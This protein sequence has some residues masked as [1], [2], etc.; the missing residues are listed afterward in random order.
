MKRFLLLAGV[1]VVAAAMYVAASPASQQSKFAT[2]KQV[3]ALQKKVATL[4]K[5]LKSVKAEADA[6]VGIIGL[7]YLDI[8]GN[9]ATFKVLP[10][11]QRGVAGTGYLFGTSGQPGTATTALDVAAASPQAYLQEVD[12]SCATG[13][14]LKHRALRS[15]ISRLRAWAEPA[16]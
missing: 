7:C 15:S 9:T 2:E 5:S 13:T 8:S 11:S 14:A 10:V 16:R 12:P 3:V 4:S 1:A 6:A